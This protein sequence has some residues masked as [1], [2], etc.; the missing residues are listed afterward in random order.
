[1]K[2]VEPQAEMRRNYRRE[3]FGK[4]ER[5]KYAD[6]MTEPPPSPPTQELMPP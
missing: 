3:D 4:L 6:R 2:K 5:G 1:M